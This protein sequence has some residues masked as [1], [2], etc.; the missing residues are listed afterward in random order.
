MVCNQ[1]TVRFLSSVNEAQAV[2][3]WP[4]NEN[5]PEGQKMERPEGRIQKVVRNLVLHDACPL[6]SSLIS[7]LLGASSILSWESL[8]RELASSSD[9]VG[10]FL[11]C[12]TV[13]NGEPFA[14]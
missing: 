8:D 3:F 9:S 6:D 11:K 5:E 1:R 14:D 13:V 4:R 2:A 12:Y 7:C 10:K